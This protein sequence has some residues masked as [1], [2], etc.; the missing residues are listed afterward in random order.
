MRSVL[1]LLAAV[2]LASSMAHAQFQVGDKD[3]TLTGGG[4][5]D[6]GVH[7]A[8]ID[9][10]ASVGY[11]ISNEVEIGLRQ[12]VSYNHALAGETSGFADY[13]FSLDSGKL[14]PFVGLSLGYT[15]GSVTKNEWGV[16]PEAGVRY[17]VNP[18]TYLYGS[19]TYQFDLNRGFSTG[20]F[21][22]NVGIG[23]RF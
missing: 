13:N 12:S 23:F 17:F 4:T 14:A 21:D 1:V 15:Y 19:L 20:E 22:Y 3:F 16:G 18:T 8:S 2:L 10:N 5:S 6:R 11:F 7:D 9:V